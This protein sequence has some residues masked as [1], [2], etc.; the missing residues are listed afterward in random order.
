MA[1]AYTRNVLVSMGK[2]AVS[3]ADGQ[4]QLQITL[5]RFKSVL[6]DRQATSC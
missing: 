2:E 3:C 4:T 1:C 5:G 6:M